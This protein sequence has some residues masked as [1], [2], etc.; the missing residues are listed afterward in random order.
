MASCAYVHRAFRESATARRDPYARF[1]ALRDH[2]V[3][4]LCNAGA[5]LGTSQLATD[6]RTRPAYACGAQPG[7]R[8]GRASGSSATAVL[9]PHGR[10]DQAPLLIEHRRHADEPAFL[11]RKPR[12]DGLKGS[13]VHHKLAHRI[14]NTVPDY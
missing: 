14:F 6:A 10:R 4:N 7:G 13:F 9:G 5:M 11:P 8:S 2:L 1:T 12:A 3:G